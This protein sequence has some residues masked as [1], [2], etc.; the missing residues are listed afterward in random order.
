MEEV[1]RIVGRRVDTLVNRR[2]GRKK[3]LGRR[4]ELVKGR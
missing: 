3:R 2:E 4:G 1:G